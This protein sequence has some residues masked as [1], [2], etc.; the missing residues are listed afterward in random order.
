MADSSLQVLNASGATTYIAAFALANSTLVMKSIPSDTNGTAAWGTAGSPNVNIMTVQG[1]T[2][3]SPIPISG[4]VAVSGSIVVAGA[5]T[6]TMLRGGTTSGTTGAVTLIAA[7]GAGTAI[8]V[9]SVQFGNTSSTAFTV[10]TLSDSATT[11]LL[12]PS[13]NSLPIVFATPL[14]VAA[15]SALTFTLSTAAATVYAAAQGYGAA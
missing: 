11:Q 2:S 5:A 15:A 10:V 9:S 4:T 8:Y 1:T 6:A 3:A 13:G 7:Q 14:R 12:V